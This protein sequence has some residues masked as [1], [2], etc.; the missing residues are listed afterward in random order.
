MRILYQNKII[1]CA[2]VSVVLMSILSG[3]S[4]NY[5]SP[6]T[7]AMQREDQRQEQVVIAISTEPSSLDP[8][9]GWG[10]GNTPLIQSTL[11]KYN[12][13]MHF[14]NDLAVDYRL[15]GTGRTWTF[16]LREDAAFT[17]GEAVTA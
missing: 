8:C 9:Q 1:L 4:S 5:G 13:E 7:H 17:D 6:Q 2:V 10:H 12:Q 14:E 15:D 11:I 16:E 3:C